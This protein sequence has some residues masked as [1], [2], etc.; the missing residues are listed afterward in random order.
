MVLSLALLLSLLLIL[1]RAVSH[2]Q[3]VEVPPQWRAGPLAIYLFSFPEDG[4]EYRGQ[5]TV[6]MAVWNARPDDPV[7]I[8][9]D[10]EEA[11]VIDCEGY[12]IFTWDRLRGSH[13]LA[14]VCRYKIFAQAAFWV[15]PP[16]PRPAM[17]PVTE[18]QERLKKEKEKVFLL[19]TLG[20]ICGIP[21][22]IETKK[23][24]KIR[25][26]WAL[27]PGITVSAI[28]LWRM[29][30]LYALIPLG[31]GWMLTYILCREYANYLAVMIIQIGRIRTFRIPI[32]QKI[33]EFRAIIGVGPRYWRNWFIETYTITFEGENESFPPTLPFEFENWSLHCIVVKGNK[34]YI[35]DHQRKAIIIRADPVVSRVLR[36][37]DVVEKI[38]R[39]L[40]RLEIENILR[41][42]GVEAVIGRVI[43][44]L[45][46]LIHE[47]ELDKV[48]RPEDIPLKIEEVM[49]R[50]RE[51]LDLTFTKAESHVE[52][53]AAA[54]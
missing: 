31:A 16:P 9:L 39:K 7:K 41:R 17:I 8:L 36:E 2:A 25:S 54:G 33:G 38:S 5:V 26:Y 35:I 21:L 37:A 12:F 50:M 40:A 13:H 18:F 19:S 47:T 14:V 24:T 44:L 46:R 29:D 15:R 43:G 28:G 4:G 49:Q 10:G 53:K 23:K 34:N 48:T 1:C 32:E 51:E 11:A 27:T 22:G 20:A 45:E 52:E 42:R 30:I 6:A 3:Q